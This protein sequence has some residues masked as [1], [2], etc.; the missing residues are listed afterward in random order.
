MKLRILRNLF[1]VWVVGGQ[2]LGQVIVPP[3]LSLSHAK[4][5]LL[6]HNPL[7]QVEGLNSEIERGNLIDG[8]KRPNPEFS[9]RSEGLGSG[10]STGTFFND[11]ELSIQLSY[12]IETAGKRRKRT[13][14]KLHGVEIA[15]TRFKDRIRLLSYELKR[16]YYQVVL[17][18]LDLRLAKEISEE[19]EQ[20]VSLHRVRYRAGEISGGELRR[21]EVEQYRFHDDVVAAEVQLENAQDHLLALLGSQD[22]LQSFQAVDDFDPSF[23]PPSRS[24][25]MEMA[26]RQREDLNAQR[27]R[28][29]QAD[30]QIDL[31]K[32]RALPNV[33]AFGG[34]RRDF[35]S[36]GAVVGVSIP[37]VV[38]NKNQGGIALAKARQEQEEWRLRL[39]EIS[40]LEQ[41][42]LAL[43]ELEGDQRR[44]RALTSDYLRNARQSRD[45][46]ESAYRLGSASPVEFLD[47]Q[48]AYRETTR[49]YNR[50]LYDFQISRA[51]L[52]LAVGK[53]L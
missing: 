45:I 9:V 32:A 29:E 13:Q 33:R 3:M 12:E 16:R 17:A 25:L 36:D 31:E 43:N 46:A 24:S 50:A 34:Y 21:T 6:E 20:I 18:Q 37:L 1:F 15:E 39:L 48:R 35:G 22:F 53:D 26:L 2:L 7:L 47:A 51:R 28:I 23:S 8:E 52:E 49:L 38:F 40:V 4:D 10:A 41:I 44:L 42:Q 11:Q 30:S 19:F 14:V 5:L 27:V